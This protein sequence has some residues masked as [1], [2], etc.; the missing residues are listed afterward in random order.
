MTLRCRAV[1]GPG[2]IVIRVRAAERAKLSDWCGFETRLRGVS[3]GQT[4]S[5]CA[6]VHLI[7]LK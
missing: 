2:R 4:G 3:S 5:D 7:A 1:S 6:R